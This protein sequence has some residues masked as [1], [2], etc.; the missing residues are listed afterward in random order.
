MSTFGEKLPPN[1]LVDGLLVRKK[2]LESTIL[3]I[4]KFLKVA[5][6][7]RL[8]ISTNKGTLQY[9]RV[10]P[11]GITSDAGKG[12][13]AGITSD[14]G[15]GNDAGIASDAGKGNDAG[16]ASDAG[17]G[18]DVGITSDAG[19]NQINGKYISKKRQSLIKE[20]AQKNYYLKIISYLQ[21]ELKLINA[22]IECVKNAGD[23]ND[24]IVSPSRKELIETVTLSD[25][26]YVS[27][28]L[29][30]EYK[31]KVFFEDVP[32]LFTA[33]GERVRSKSEVIIADTLTR[34]NVPYRYEFPVALKNVIV[35][36]DFY[37]LNV[38][39]REEFLWEHFGMM[40]DVEYSKAAVEKLMLYQSCGIFP[41]A[42]L[43][44]ST[45][46][47]TKPLSTKQIEQIVKK[48]LI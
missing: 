17:K 28:W 4:E 42:N 1:N 35:H 5:P 34:L 30:L 20:L 38:R 22:L 21:D 25:I 39:T 32:E 46:T 47:Q 23:V 6:A 13:V 8:R 24:N 14:A 31:H 33:K 3:G 43:L 40:S 48:F 18:N 9:Y 7:G 37:C 16:I 12:K 44:I 45:E 29:V 15:K 41:G 2:Q 19:K 26:E 36:P 10:M 11:A 27:R